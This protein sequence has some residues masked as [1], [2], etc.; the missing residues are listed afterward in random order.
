[1]ILQPT[2]ENFP[3]NYSLVNFSSF[4][5]VKAKYINGGKEMK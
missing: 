1:M 4:T 5:L 2:G 3:L